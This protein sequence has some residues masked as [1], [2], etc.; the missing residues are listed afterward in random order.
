MRPA[1]RNRRRG[2]PAGV[3]SQTPGEDPAR[4]GNY[5]SGTIGG[6]CQGTFHFPEPRRMV[7]IGPRELSLFQGEPFYWIFPGLKPCASEACSPFGFGPGPV[8]C[9]SV[10]SRTNSLEPNCLHSSRTIQPVKL[11][12]L[13][14]GSPSAG[15]SLGLTGRTST[16]F[17]LQELVPIPRSIISLTARRIRGI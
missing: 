7:R 14:A 12:S 17:S 13:A 8:G 4:F 2:H 9:F 15:N 1:S 10:N 5:A 3:A 16:C 11:P 6:L